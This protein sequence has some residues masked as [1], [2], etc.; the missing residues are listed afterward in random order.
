MLR[1][2]VDAIREFWGFCRQHG[3][4]LFLAT[5]AAYAQQHY[6]L[7]GPPAH[8]LLLPGLAVAT[9]FA[10]PV[11][12][13]VL[14]DT[15]DRLAWALATVGLFAAMGPAMVWGYWPDGDRLL[16]LDARPMAW[17]AMAGAVLV[18]A[19]MARGRIA[20][21]DWGL[22]AGDLAWWRRPVGL[23]L[24]MIFVG[25]P[26]T[27]WLFP[28]F[29]QYYPRYKPARTDLGQ[30]V[31]YELAMGVYMFCWEF[32]FR[33][34]LLFGLARTLGPTASILVQAYPFF[35]LHQAKPEPEMVS[36]WFGGILMGWLCWRAKSAWPSFLLHWV[37]YSTMEVTA[38]VVRNA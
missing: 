12:A 9:F 10:M 19:G 32:F 20:W 26:I 36:S 28:E 8:L 6:D 29:A 37:L 38:F 15:R 23:L 31:A 17:G 35:I 14:H 30:L 21:S 18:M 7:Y 2:M 13:A 11:W 25:I 16:R 34:Y 24:V 4:M 3:G 22:G 1:P 5:V 33:G 27:V